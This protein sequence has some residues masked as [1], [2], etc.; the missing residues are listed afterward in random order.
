[1]YKELT[2]EGVGSVILNKMDVFPARIYKGKHQ[3]RQSDG[4]NEG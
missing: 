4:E 3:R 2:I 1:M